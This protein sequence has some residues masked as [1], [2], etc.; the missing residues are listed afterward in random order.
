[1][2]RGA[3]VAGGNP[4]LRPR[5]PWRTVPQATA[6]DGA[7]PVLYEW[8]TYHPAPGRMEALHRRFAEHTRRLFA[9]HGIRE[10]GY[11]TPAGAEGPL[12]YLLA[13]PDR[14]AREASWEAF[15]A[16]PEWQ[17][18]KAESERDGALLTR[19]DS[20]LLEPTSYSPQP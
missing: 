17:R 6:K 15:R 11:F 19:V 9:R 3:A 4:P 8:R 10:I 5:P 12:H 20:L 2:L 16:D 14:A 7:A 18:I 1:M 13:Y